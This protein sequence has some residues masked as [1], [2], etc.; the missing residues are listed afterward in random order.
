M[1]INFSILYETSCGSGNAE[2]KWPP[3]TSSRSQF[4]YHIIYLI[5]IPFITT[6]KVNAELDVPVLINLSNRNIILHDVPS[7]NCT[8][9]LT[10]RTLTTVNPTLFGFW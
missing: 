6:S 7:S 2:M 1:E 3:W 9:L 5:N 8:A 4:L 10:A